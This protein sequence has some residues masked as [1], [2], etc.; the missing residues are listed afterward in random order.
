MD[1]EEQEYIL[2]MLMVLAAAVDGNVDQI[3]KQ[4]ITSIVNNYSHFPK[5]PAGFIEQ[6]TRDIGSIGLEGTELIKHLTKNLSV[7]FVL[8]G[9]AFAYEVCAAD[10]EF[11]VEEKKYLR[12][13]KRVLKVP[14]DHANAM[15]ISIQSRYFPSDPQE[16]VIE[17]PI[18]GPNAKH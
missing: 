6:A 9:L 13:L 17:M 8:P 2:I 4:R 7:D 1:Q 18:T 12:D 14:D 16:P 5:P 3:E 10:G 11:T 15:E